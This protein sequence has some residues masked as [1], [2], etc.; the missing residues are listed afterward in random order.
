MNPGFMKEAL[1]PEI[2]L[3]G[4]MGAVD[5]FVANDLGAAAVGII[6]TER[7][8]RQAVDI[9]KAM[10]IVDKTPVELA[11]VLLPI[12]I[13]NPK[14]IL[15]TAREIGVEAI[16]LCNSEDLPALQQ[17]YN[18]RDEFSLIQVFHIDENVRYSKIKPFFDYCD[19]VHFDSRDGQKLG[20][21]GK[22][23]DWTI[24]AVMAN[25]AH[26]FNIPVILSGGLNADNVAEAINTVRPD[27]VDVQTAIKRPDN[28]TSINEATKFIDKVQSHKLDYAPLPVY[29]DASQL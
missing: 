18:C 23:H 28:F 11:T 15:E 20:G 5:T 24:S 26:E 16:Q 6:V 27:A 10:E 13:E 2:K 21:T 19:A 12:D 25:A 14:K 1:S 3:C 9:E 22:T 29:R 7:Q 17:L 8:S 4:A